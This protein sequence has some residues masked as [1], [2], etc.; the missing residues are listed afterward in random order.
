MAAAG[1]V[2][3]GGTLASNDPAPP[4]PAPP[5]AP[6]AARA[7]FQTG[8]KVDPE[9]APCKDGF[10]SVKALLKAKDAGDAAAAAGA[11]PAAAEAYSAG[12]ALH[13]HNRVWQREVR[14]RGVGAAVTPRQEGGAGG[15]SREEGRE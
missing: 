6:P 2:S 13:G 7:H 14:V 8:L 5:P 4:V 12:A 11:W 3:D 1:A 10:R 9:D 15:G